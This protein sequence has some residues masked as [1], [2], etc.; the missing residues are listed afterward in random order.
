MDK[1]LKDEVNWCKQSIQNYYKDIKFN[2]QVLDEYAP[3]LDN[4]TQLLNHWIK[5]KSSCQLKGLMLGPDFERIILLEIERQYALKYSEADQI[6]SVM[7]SLQITRKLSF[8]SLYLNGYEA[9]SYWP[10]I[11]EIKRV[12]LV[13]PINFIEIDKAIKSPQIKLVIN[14]IKSIDTGN[15]SLFWSLC[16]EYNR[17]CDSCLANNWVNKYKLKKEWNKPNSSIAIKELF[18]QLLMRMGYDRNWSKDSRLGKTKQL[19]KDYLEQLNYLFN[20]VLKLNIPFEVKFIANFH[21]NRG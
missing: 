15:F 12:L 11:R 14:I 4:P 6:V 3:L 20:D 5:F 1:Q 21:G 2:Q 10:Y 16:K 13:V 8:V 17:K 7:D 18:R 9:N 19:K